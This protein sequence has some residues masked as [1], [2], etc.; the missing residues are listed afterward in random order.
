MLDTKGF[1]GHNASTVIAPETTSPASSGAATANLL[2]SLRQRIRSGEYPAG[3]WLPP[4][5]DLAEEFGVARRAVRRAI[6]QLSEEGLVRCRPR[7]RPVVEAPEAASAPPTV[8]PVSTAASRLVALVMWHGGPD[9]RGVSAQQRIFWGMNQ[10]LARDGYH[11]VFLDLGEYVGTEPENARSEANHLRYAQE[12]GFAGIIFY[13]YAYRSNRELIQETARHLP[14]VLIDRMVPGVQADFVGVDNHRAMYDV[15]Q[16]LLTQGHRR[17]LFISTAE[18]IN[19]VQDRLSGY[20]QALAEFPGERGPLPENVLTALTKWD[21]A[22]WPV[23]ESLFALPAEQRPTAILCVND[24]IAV[25]VYNRLQ[26]LG[27]R[28]PED[29][30]L[31]GFDDIIPY[32]PNGIGLTTVF[33]PFEQIGSAAAE[34]F[35]QRHAEVPSPPSL[36]HTEL[37]ARLMVRGST[38][39][40]L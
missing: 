13:A 27:L 7:F 22:E 25:N 36:I 1:P 28:V 26:A 8:S 5:R 11:G 19:T 38:A 12:Q 6:E 30:A 4:E 17:I 2:S 33:Q 14:L 10:R 40:G 34:A 29:I 23:F 16:H 20:R 35:L 3:S 32:L 31:T 18:P 15:T 21:T 9:E 39:R 24:H 37:P